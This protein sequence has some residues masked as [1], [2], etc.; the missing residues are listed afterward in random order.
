[1]VANKLGPLLVIVGETASGKSALAIELAKKFNGEIIAADSRTVYRGMDIGTA[2]PSKTDQAL[3]PHHL[4]DITTPDKS[5]NA[6][7][8]KQLANQAIKDITTRN[9]L[10]ILVG[11]TGLYIDAVIFDYQFPS[12]GNSMMRDSL[13][14]LSVE[15]LQEQLR[16]QGLS[17][18]KNQRNPRHLIRTLEIDGAPITRKSLRANTL[19]IGLRVDRQVLKRRIQKRVDA[20][21]AN[22]LVEEA[23]KL[24][25]EYGWEVEAL[26]T[27]GYKAFREYIAGTISLQQAKEQFIKNDIHLA[28][29]QR[30]WFKR[31][32]SIHWITEQSDTVDL[33]TTILNK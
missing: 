12:V 20:M 9:K 21:V 17:L 26:R 7:T 16:S 3:V 24:G 10:P 6:A 13:A 29:R 4:L 8:F 1:V 33:I 31:N 5:L 15:Q 18:P 28:K 14:V 19:V 22:G 25:H 23:R 30:T 27:P 32:E 2:K 11:G